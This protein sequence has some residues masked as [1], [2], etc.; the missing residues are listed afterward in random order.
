MLRNRLEDNRQEP[1]REFNRPV[2]LPHAAVGFDRFRRD[3][4]YDRVGLRNQATEA[5]LPILASRDVAAVEEWRE[6]TIF[7][8]CYQFVGERGRILPRIGNEDLELLSCASI[9]HGYRRDLNQ[10]RRL[11]LGHYGEE[12]HRTGLLIDAFRRSHRI[13]LRYHGHH[14]LLRP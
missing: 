3:D 4:K 9:G 10:S 6:A 5:R 1:L 12:L 2:H 8:T 11:T 7:E 13:G 14:W